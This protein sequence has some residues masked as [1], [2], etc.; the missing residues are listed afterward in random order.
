MTPLT[1]RTQIQRQRPTGIM[2]R[3]HIAIRI[4][5]SAAAPGRIEEEDGVGLHLGIG[6]EKDGGVVRAAHARRP[7]P[8]NAEPGGHQEMRCA[9]LFRADR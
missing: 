2:T 4:D 5:A 7:C 9:M 8:V 3:P 1:P 6:V